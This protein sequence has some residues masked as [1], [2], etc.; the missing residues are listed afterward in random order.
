MIEIL[1]GATDSEK[2]AVVYRV[3]QDNINDSQPFKDR[4]SIDWD[5]YIGNHW[6]VNPPPG[7][8]KV[9]INYI[10]TLMDSLV[11]FMVGS[12]PE[13]EPW[14]IDGSIYSEAAYKVVNQL[15]KS[16]WHRNQMMANLDIW[17][18][19]TGVYGLGCMGLA[20]P[21]NREPEP[22]V[23]PVLIDPY[24]VGFDL[25]AR[26]WNPQ[27]GDFL[28]RFFMADR[29][30]TEKNFGVELTGEEDPDHNL[31]LSRQKDT[32]PIG[33][34]AINF[35]R[36]SYQ[37]AGSAVN[38]GEPIN[39]LHTQYDT[40]DEVLVVQMHFRDFSKKKG[41]S[42]SRFSI[43]GQMIEQKTDEQVDSYPGNIRVLTVAGGKLIDDAASQWQKG[44]W[45]GK[46]PIIVNNHV[47]RSDSPYGISFPSRLEDIQVQLNKKTSLLF[48][49][50]TQL[51]KTPLIIPDGLGIKTS[52]IGRRAGLILRPTNAL[53][54][55]Y[56]RFLATPT[57]PAVAVEAI[58]EL[59]THM[60]RIG[61]I[62][63]VTEG[64]KPSGVTAASAI[65]AL[66]EKA[67]QK[68][69]HQVRNQ[70]V[71]IS[72][73]GNAV[74]SGM[75]QF[76]IEPKPYYGFDDIGNPQRLEYGGNPEIS[77]AYI[78]SQSKMR[79]R[80]RAAST[81]EISKYALEERYTDLYAKGIIDEFMLI[82]ALD[83]PG[84]ER[85]KEYLEAK[86]QIESVEA[87]MGGGLLPSVGGLQ[88]GEGGPQLPPQITA[89]G[90]QPNQKSKP[91]G[92]GPGLP[93]EGKSQ[94]K[95]TR[96]RQAVNKVN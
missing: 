73:L 62:P 84:K 58:R 34:N 36:V 16:W 71:A 69:Q 76:Y 96:V 66:Q 78:I 59:L 64:R 12:N 87:S 55:R 61:G 37:E 95:A 9:T 85:I 94:T 40:H 2:A 5:M 52:K 63:D 23:K 68:F 24:T 49:W 65:I 11:S 46:Y 3:F 25:A 14:P 13:F 75:E 17:Q 91:G 21:D 22:D 32:A 77:P 88:Q 67:K 31:M 74:L 43:A 90:P 8:E 18:R 6:R 15:S 80:M 54:S 19:D 42:V 20:P 29:K 38:M 83:M 41:Q 50:F 10:G 47:R 89:G 33:E 45:R 79:I 60:E 53:M 39:T 26:S 35:P 70:G 28:L 82:E 56:I 27:D 57:V 48:D 81:L 86:A 92:G 93:L 7:H 30:A 72:E 1:P 44:Y 51:P 4:M